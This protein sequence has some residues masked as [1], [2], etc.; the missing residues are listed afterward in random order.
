MSKKILLIAA[1]I[2]AILTV[3]GSVAWASSS[4]QSDPEQQ[5]SY[6]VQPAEPF[7]GV[8]LANI[9]PRLA[10]RLDLS[11]GQGVVIIEVIADSPAEQAGLQAKDI[12]LKLGDVQTSSVDDV[13]NQVA[14]YQ[15]GSPVTLTILRAGFQQTITVTLGEKP[16]SPVTNLRGRLWSGLEQLPMPDIGGWLGELLPRMITPCELFDR[17]LGGELR[18][19][20]KDGN[21]VTREIVPGTVS[22]VVGNMLT[23]NTNENIQRTFDVPEDVTIRKGFRSVALGELEIGDKVVI[24]LVNGKVTAILVNSD[25]AIDSFL[26]RLGVDDVPPMPRLG[27]RWDSLPQLFDQFRDRF[28]EHL[29]R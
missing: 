11:Q 9:T 25:L 24:N 2:V 18:Y 13:L 16:P 1:V 23:V 19:L 10:D 4:G 7:I 14:Q 20:D 6:Q 29:R 8:K 27:D 15:V 21:P 17:F 12:I 3:T 28:R 22:S 5:D 26:P